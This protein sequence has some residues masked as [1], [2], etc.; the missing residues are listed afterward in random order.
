[1]FTIRAPIIRC[2]FGFQ[3][4]PVLTVFGYQTIINSACKTKTVLSVTT[5]C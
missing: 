4:S 5:Q 2:C 1:M 3:L